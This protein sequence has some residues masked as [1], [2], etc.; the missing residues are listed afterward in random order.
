M[1]KT[2]TGE[3]KPVKK[4]VLFPERDNSG[5]IFYK[6]EG[7]LNTDYFMINYYYDPDQAKS[8]FTK[9]LEA[10]MRFQ[11]KYLLDL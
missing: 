10:L 2:W 6:I 9:L 11:T 3:E 7:Q 1:V 5:D 4:I 8:E